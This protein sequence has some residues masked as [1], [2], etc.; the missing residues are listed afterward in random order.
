MFTAIGDALFVPQIFATIHIRAA[1]F[2][3]RRNANGVV[4]F[5]VDSAR[6]AI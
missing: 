3:V 1:N 4:A 6:N 5:I 2:V